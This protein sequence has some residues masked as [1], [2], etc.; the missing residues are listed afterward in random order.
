MKLGP[1]ISTIRQN[2]NLHLADVEAA[3]GISVDDLRNI[4][5][6]VRTP[7]K[8]EIAKIGSSLDVPPPILIY[9]SID[10]TDIDP[11]KLAAFSELDPLMKKFL[12]SHIFSKEVGTD[13][14]SNL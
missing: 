5:L 11:Q 13:G 8:D 10:V 3:T 7:S 14:G 2:R 1:T 9:L 6:G 4:E 12:H